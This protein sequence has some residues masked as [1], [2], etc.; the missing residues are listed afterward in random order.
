MPVR[1][2][3]WKS[4]RRIHRDRSGIGVEG[5]QEVIEVYSDRVLR[6]LGFRVNAVVVLESVE[7]SNGYGQKW[8]AM[9][10][11]KSSVCMRI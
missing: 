10:Y 3:S 1:V 8:Y 4:Y 2:V 5:S 9:S 6:G 11:S 7:V